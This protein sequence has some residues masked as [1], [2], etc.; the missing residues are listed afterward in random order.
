MGAVIEHPTASRLSELDRERFLQEVEEREAFN[1]DLALAFRLF[2]GA[3]TVPGWLWGARTLLH[4][5]WKIVWR[6]DP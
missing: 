4:G 1:R 3:H 2:F 6:S 5:A